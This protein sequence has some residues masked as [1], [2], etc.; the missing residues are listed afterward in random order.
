MASVHDVAACILEEAGEL[1]TMKLQK[2]VYYCQAWSL[3]WDGKP[4]FDADI[5]AWINGPVV[6]E[7]YN[8]HAGQFTVDSWQEGDCTNLTD[9]ERKTVTAVIKFYGD[10]SGQW[11]SQ[12]THQELPW[13]EARKGLDPTERGKKPISL[14]TMQQYYASL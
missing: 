13:K 1:T 2:L 6:R 4:I 12:L 3:V 8:W 14:E 9:E 5:E 11:L 7:L 10:K